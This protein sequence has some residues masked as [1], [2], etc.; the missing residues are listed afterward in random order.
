MTDKQG[1]FLR[2]R[3]VIVVGAGPVGCLSA[4]SFAKQGWEV[5]VFEARPGKS[6][7]HCPFRKR[8]WWLITRSALPADM[9]EPEAKANLSLRSIN[10]AISSRGISALCVVDPA[11]ADRFMQNVIPMH[12]RMIHDNLGHCQSQLYDRDGQVSNS[13]R[14]RS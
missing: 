6:T 1:E 10:L 7:F 11:I 13:T 14:V 3:K 8:T 4:L 12:G 2:P 5:E 9:R